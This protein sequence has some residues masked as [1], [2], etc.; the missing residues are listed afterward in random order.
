M[1]MRHRRA[2]PLLL[3]LL[4]CLS[5]PALAQGTSRTGG[6]SPHLGWNG[7]G[8]RVGLSSSPDQ[9]YGGV[10]FDLG[11]FAR[12]VRFRPYVEIGTGDHATTLQGIA[13][14][15][16]LFSKVQVWKPYVGGG[17]GFTYVHIDNAPSG[18]DN[19]DTAVAL[20]GV[21]GVETRLKSG[22]KFFAELK[23]GLGDDDADY[24]IGVGWSWK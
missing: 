1:T 20:M 8:A 15:T 5:T 12:N 14:V 17:T 4:V 3:L 18:V 13:E 24:K 23:V 11:E 22:T 9:V 16:Y 10:H 19:S 6:P 7:W 21:G 2:L